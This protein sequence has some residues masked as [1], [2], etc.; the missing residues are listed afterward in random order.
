MKTY[1]ICVLSMKF[2]MRDKT[3]CNKKYICVD[4][5]DGRSSQPKLRA[6]F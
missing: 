2:E 4:K 1:T 3:K 6:A 5:V